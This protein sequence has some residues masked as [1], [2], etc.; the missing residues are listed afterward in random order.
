VFAPEPG[1]AKGDPTITE[2]RFPFQLKSTV[3]LQVFL[4]APGASWLLLVAFD[5]ASTA[6]S[7]SMVPCGRFSLFFVPFASI[8][9]IR[10]ADSYLQ[11][12]IS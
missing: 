9:L 3:A 11:V 2:I 12:E 10:I 8:P 6:V 1:P 4:P 5:L 7:A